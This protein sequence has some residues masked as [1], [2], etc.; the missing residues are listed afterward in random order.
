[1]I[2]GIFFNLFMREYVNTS[3]VERQAVRV[4]SNT[5][6]DDR[7]MCLYG[8]LLVS[9]VTGIHLMCYTKY[10]LGSVKSTL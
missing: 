8:F 7:L 9:A 3:S 1:M 5:N 10:S 2:I 4:K 6:G